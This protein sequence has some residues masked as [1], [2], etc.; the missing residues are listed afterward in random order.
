[1]TVLFWLIN[2]G[3]GSTWLI[4]PYW[5]LVPPLVCML[6]QYHPKAEADPMRAAVLLVL[7]LVWAARLTHNYLRR[8]QWHF[9]WREDWRFAEYVGRRRHFSAAVP[10][11]PPHQHP[12]DRCTL[13]SSSHHFRTASRV[14]LTH[15]PA[16]LAQTRESLRPPFFRS[17]S[18]ARLRYFLPRSRARG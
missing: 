14:I 16:R 15:L 11:Y 5:T 7:V 17:A 10:N 8:E 1:M 13:D 6:Y 9:G 3:Q 2:L 12:R 4:D 18:T